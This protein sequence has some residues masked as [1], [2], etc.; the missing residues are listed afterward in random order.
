MVS[1]A[2]QEQRDMEYDGVAYAFFNSNAQ[3][4]EL[5]A[6][7]NDIRRLEDFPSDLELTL[8]DV[9]ELKQDCETDPVLM[10]LI[11][12]KSI[13]PTFPPSH[14]SQMSSAKSTPLRDLQ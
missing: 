10:R 4:E 14:R 5:E 8:G 13:Y 7:L 6:T 12:Q 2:S 9:R 1:I 11:N 3:K